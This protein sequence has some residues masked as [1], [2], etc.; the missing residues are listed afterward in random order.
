M[1]GKLRDK[2]A[3]VKQYPFRKEQERRSS[4][5]LIR[6]PLLLDNQWEDEDYHLE[7]DEKSLVAAEELKK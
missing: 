6:T 5:R 4:K 7:D 3:D 2:R 1:R